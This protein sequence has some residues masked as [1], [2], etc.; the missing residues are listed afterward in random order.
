MIH[1]IFSYIRKF[2][3]N[4]AKAA[5]EIAEDDLNLWTGFWWI[6]L[7]YFGYSVTV[8]IFYMMGHTPVDVTFLSVPHKEWYLLQTFTTIPVGLAGALSFSGLTY[9]FSRAI[10]GKGTFDATFASQAFT[11]NIPVLIF[12]WIPE[13]FLFPFFYAMGF[14]SPP[15]PGWIEILRIF[16]IPFTWIF[17][18]S[19]VAL[20]RIHKI[21]RWKSFIIVLVSL[22]PTMMIMAVFIR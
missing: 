15:W 1:R 14:Q 12:M 20:G 19:T 6:I 10:S 13:T 11:I 4:P 2:I 7:F 5:E 3:I 18:M 22:I 21:S 17:F 9:I 16:V 8:F